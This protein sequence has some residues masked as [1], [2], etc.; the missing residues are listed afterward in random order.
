MMYE[1]SYLTAWD[2]PTFNDSGRLP[3]TMRGLTSLHTLR[4]A[5]NDLTGPIP[6]DRGKMLKLEYV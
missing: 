1:I 6:S 2:G 4:A 5:D 3:I